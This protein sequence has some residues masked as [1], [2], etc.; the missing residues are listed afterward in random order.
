M[1]EAENSAKVEAQ[2]RRWVERAVIGLNLCPFAK[3]VA[4]KEQIRYVVSQATAPDTLLEDLRR[5]LLHLA[6]ADPQAVDTTL[7][8]HPGVLQDFLDF[9][10]FLGRAQELL[11][12]LDLVGELQIADFHPHY[13]FADSRVDDIENCTNRAPY[14]TLHLLREASI[15]RAVEAFPEAETIYEANMDTLRRLGHEGW[16]RLMSQTD[17]E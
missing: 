4:V 10:D 8:V 16:A 6:A 13:Q 5:E 14:P 12:E 7:L 9:N 15:D 11:E 3:A 2:M 17:T 1:S